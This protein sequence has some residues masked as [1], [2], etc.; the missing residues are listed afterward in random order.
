MG[1]VTRR[2]SVE[3]DKSGNSAVQ[4]V[5]HAKREN[6]LNIEHDGTEFSMSCESWDKLVSLV[7]LVRAINV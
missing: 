4:E 7:Q 6:W 2:Q 3:L 1:V 5:T